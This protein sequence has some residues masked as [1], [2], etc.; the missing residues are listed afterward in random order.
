MKVIYDI[1]VLGIGFFENRARTGIARVV[2]NLAIELSQRSDLELR[3]S[4]YQSPITF[5]QTLEYLHTQKVLQAKDLAR[6]ETGFGRKF[7]SLYE[8]LGLADSRLILSRNLMGKLNRRAQQELYTRFLAEIVDLSGTTNQDIL[9]TPFLPFP[10][11]SE[12]KT[13]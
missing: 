13:T 9:H 10:K 1:S 4:A 11:N 3:F 6:P 12:Q 5:Y 2:D 7:I 8:R